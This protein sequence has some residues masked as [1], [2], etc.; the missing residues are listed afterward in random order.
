MTWIFGGDFPTFFKKNKKFLG[1][2]AMTSVFA[3]P[4]V[5]PLVHVRR[6]CDLSRYL[7]SNLAS[8][9]W[10]ERL[11]QYYDDRELNIY[12]EMKRDFLLRNIY[13]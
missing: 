8:L 5:G 11:L 1:R 2:L 4:Q 3:R 6:E 13:L 7:N 12:R 9:M 10:I